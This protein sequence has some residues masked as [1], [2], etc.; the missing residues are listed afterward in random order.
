MKHICFGYIGGKKPIGVSNLC[1]M[2]GE[3]ES[4]TTTVM[5][6][7]GTNETDWLIDISTKIRLME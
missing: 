3:G 1:A 6:T 2:G 4:T 7:I 5:E